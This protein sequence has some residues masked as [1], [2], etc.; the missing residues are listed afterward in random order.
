MWNSQQ[1]NEQNT[2]SPG[3]VV[4]DTACK[5]K[6]YLKDTGQR[7]KAAAAVCKEKAQQ[8]TG[9]CKH[10]AQAAAAVCKDKAQAAAT[11]C[12][13]KGKAVVAAVYR[14]KVKDFV[15]TC[16]AKTK[17]AAAVCQAKGKRVVAF[18]RE[19]G[20]L[21][22]VFCGDKGKVIAAFCKEKGKVIVAAVYRGK[23]KEFVT[24][25][26]DKAKAAAAVCKAKGKV[27]AA[28]C[29]S[30]AQAASAVCKA[31]AQAAGLVAHDLALIAWVKG[32]EKAR[33]QWDN[34]CAV[35]HETWEKAGEW[36]G[37]VRVRVDRHPVSPLL[38]VTL[39]S[40]GIGAIAFNGMYT[41]AYVAYVDGQEVGVVS[42]EEEMSSIV[43][44]VETRVASVLGEEYSYDTEITLAPTYLDAGTETNARAIEDALFE[45]TGAMMDA[46]AISVDGQELGYAKTREELEQLLDEVLK[47]YLTEQT[48]EHKFLQDVQIFPVELPSNTEFN[49]EALLATLSGNKEE[50]QYISVERGDTFNK[51]AERAGIT[52]DELQALNPN[53]DSGKLMVGDQLL[54]KQAV[55][56]LTVQTVVTETYE[57][58]IESPVEYVETD[59]LYKGTTK[60]KEEGQDG[61]ERIEARVTMVNG[62]ET[63]REEVSRTTVQEATTTYMYQ[64]TKEKPATASNGYF[65]WPLRGTITS[66]F[67]YRDIFG[68]TSFHSGL[69]IAAP[70]G[71][72]ISAADGGT[73]TFAGWRNSYGMT[74]II[75]HDDGTV[76]YYAHCSSLLVSAGDK[77]Y[78][79]QAIARVGMT[80]T[81]TGYH[82]H[83]EV[84]VNGQSV[85][86]ENYL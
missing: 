66:R 5:V 54:T 49:S 26:R 21:V 70:Y 51:I 13:D 52:A 60:L 31:K 61:V 36:A 24:W 74:V 27:V 28:F 75:R 12:K 30:K 20:K 82:C 34:T 6:G 63:Q 7:A 43:G 41:K 16:K 45:D 8:A 19:K 3:R 62:V 80:G 35:A 76:T 29:Q 67:G 46:Y 2:N 58:T 25:C 14:G 4:H 68:G 1:D 69:D 57:E 83:F 22:A 42:S 64:G 15:T 55:R 71:T 50:E 65:I 23:V 77:V 18:C 17:A 73:V 48:V 59:S 81:A 85:N 40:V 56:T 84:R 33:T 9:V 39:L 44:N 53:V 38:Y 37:R 32:C 86:P 79:G 72:Q 78:Q 47:P 11:V 10:K